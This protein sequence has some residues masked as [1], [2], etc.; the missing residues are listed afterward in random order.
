VDDAYDVCNQIKLAL[1]TKLASIAVD[2]AASKQQ[3]MLP[4]S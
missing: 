4:K 3:T 2:N 1:N